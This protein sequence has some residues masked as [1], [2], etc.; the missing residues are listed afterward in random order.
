M[1]TNINREFSIDD[2]QK[3]AQTFFFMD[4]SKLMFGLQS[5]KPTNIELKRKV[6]RYE[7]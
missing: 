4:M 6:D 3:T 5:E 1:K 2:V 7:A